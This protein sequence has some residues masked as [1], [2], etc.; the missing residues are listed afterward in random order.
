[1]KKREKNGIKK[2]YEQHNFLHRKPFKHL[3]EDVSKMY[4]R[5]KLALSD[6][7]LIL[8]MIIGINYKGNI[9]LRSVEKIVKLF[10]IES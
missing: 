1:M 5:R 8:Y 6:Y 4:K 7:I 2:M 10:W 3:K 9:S